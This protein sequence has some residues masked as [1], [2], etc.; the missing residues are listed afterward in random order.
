MSYYSSSFDVINE[1]Y[2]NKIH[3]WELKISSVSP[4]YWDVKENRIK[5]VRWLIKDKLKFSHDEVINSLS[6]E[7]FYMNRLSTLIC[8][9]YNKSIVR[10]ITEAFED[11][12]IPWEF[13]Y[14]RWNENDAK[15]ATKWLIEKLNKE[16]G[17]LPLEINYYDFQENKLRTVII[18]IFKIF[19]YSIYRNSIYGEFRFNL[20]IIHI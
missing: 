2:P 10:A 5:A 3:P 7:D 8:H 20:I 13:G 17:K 6:I 12:F 11:E 16:E 9:Y 15:K 1:I 4:K 14:H 19:I 18:F